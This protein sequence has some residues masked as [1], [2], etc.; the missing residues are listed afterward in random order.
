ML[1]YGDGPYSFF[2]SG[3]TTSQPFYQSV[4]VYIN[5]GWAAPTPS[6]AQSFWIDM[7]AN[8]SNADPLNYLGTE[9]NFRL[10]ANGSAVSVS[11][12]GQVSPISTITS[13]GWYD[14]QMTYGSGANG[15]DPVVTDMNVFSLDGA[16]NPNG[17]IGTTTVLGNSDGE[18]TTGN[19]LSGSGYL[20]FTVW[21]NGSAN[22]TLDV[23]NVEASAVPE[24]TT[25]GCF[26]LGLGALICSRRFRKGSV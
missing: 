26:L 15:T 25:A 20:W 12:D 13:S 1:G 24:P 8:S 6:Y 7:A 5:A 3:I 9:H 16:G 19:D 23:A 4:D 2:G 11:V 14:F 22:D 10:T 21:A 17:L 18:V